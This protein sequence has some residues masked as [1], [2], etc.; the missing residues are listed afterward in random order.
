MSAK[1]AYVG[2]QDRIR[3]GE[4]FFREVWDREFQYFRFKKGANGK[5]FFDVSRR[6]RG[7]DGAAVGHDGDQT[8]SFQL[9]ERFADRNAADLV[10][11][12]DGVLAKLSAFWNLAADDLIAQFVGYR[13][14]KRLAGDRRV[15]SALKVHF[16]TG[17]YR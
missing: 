17:D 6:E 15:W 2:A 4:I 5:Q 10:L 16:E 13:R 3:F 9:A 1:F 8:F 7:D 12:R 11:G 14:G